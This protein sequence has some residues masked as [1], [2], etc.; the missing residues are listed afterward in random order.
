MA[1]ALT[2]A[3]ALRWKRWP[4]YAKSGPRTYTLAQQLKAVRPDWVLPAPYAHW[5]ERY[6][7]AG[8]QAAV[9]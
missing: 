8:K 3:P 1:A 6:R 4:P 9:A 5:L 7:G 2:T